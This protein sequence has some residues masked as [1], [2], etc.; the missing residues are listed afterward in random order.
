LS[1]N[2]PGREERRVFGLA[3]V[4]VL[5]IASSIIPP[6]LKLPGRE[7]RRV[8]GLALVQVLLIASSINPPGEASSSTS[9]LHHMGCISNGTLFSCIVQ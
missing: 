3:L 6:D 9:T 7:E 2:L 1:W 5:L 4:Q 8:F